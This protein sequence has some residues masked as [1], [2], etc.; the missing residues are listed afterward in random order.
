M[1]KNISHCAISGQVNYRN[2]RQDNDIAGCHI[3]VMTESG[4]QF[5]AAWRK[6]RGL[7]QAEA[8]EATGIPQ[9]YLSALERGERRYNEDHLLALSTAYECSPADLLGVD[10]RSDE[11]SAEIVNIWNHI[12]PEN[13][14]QARQILETFT[15]KKKA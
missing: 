4:T 3:Q 12:L 14:G 7:T 9:G 1:T 10:P 11:D 13:R 5:F 15:G 2:V 8:S 6:H